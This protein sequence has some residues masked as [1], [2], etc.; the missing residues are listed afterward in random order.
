MGESSSMSRELAALRASRDL[1]REVSTTSDL[2]RTSRAILEAACQI[3]GIDCGGIYLVDQ[4]TGSLHLT[5]HRGLPPGF[6]DQTAFYAG[7]AP[8]MALVRAGQAI[9]LDDVGLS[10]LEHVPSARLCAAAGLQAVAILPVQFDGRVVAALNL[11]SHT[12]REIPIPIRDA[13]EVMTAPLG[14]A[15]ARVQMEAALRQANLVVE[16]SPVVLFRW[17]AAAGWP[18]EYVSGNV[19]QF[20]YTPHELLTGGTPYT[21]LVHP[22][23]LTRV[24]REVQQYS[25][26]GVDRFQQEYRI[27]TKDGGVRWVDDRTAI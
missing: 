13:L 24:A 22:D 15:L 16:N 7:D 20:G 1:L 17:K 5:A 18:V 10:A 23:D 12:L 26:S 6:I 2:T 14:G 25:D 19:I 4:G 11:G 9:Y 21:S 27:L 3:E 8:E